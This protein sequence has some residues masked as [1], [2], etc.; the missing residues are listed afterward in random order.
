MPRKPMSNKR[1]Q[2][3]TARERKATKRPWTRHDNEYPYYVWA[4]YGQRKG[5]Y[6]ASCWTDDADETS[7]ANADFIANSRQDIPDLLAEIARLRGDDAT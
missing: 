4:S 5:R 7:V 3:I 6:I 2:E 1:L